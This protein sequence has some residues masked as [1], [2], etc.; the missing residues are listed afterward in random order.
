MNFA[1]Q[2]P[3]HMI[4][5]LRVLGGIALL[6][7]IVIAFFWPHAAMRS[8]LFG[9]LFFIDLTLG[10]LATLGMLYASGGAWGA[11]ARRI[12]EAGALTLPLLAVL[13]LPLLIGAPWVFPW[14]D[15]AEIAAEPVIAH[16]LPWIGLPWVAT[17]GVVF[18]A[19]LIGVTYW[20][21][22]LSIAWDA[23]SPP[24]LEPGARSDPEEPATSE[25]ST[26]PQSL[27]P[28]PL[29]QGTLEPLRIARRLD[30]LGRFVLCALFVIVSFWVVDFIMALEPKYTSTAFG[31]IMLCGQACGAMCVVILT[32]A[33]LQRR[34]PEPL[35]PPDRVHDLGKLLLTNLVMWAYT[36]FAQFL[37]QWQ[38]NTQ[39]DIPFYVHRTESWWRWTGTALIF[40]HLGLPF[41]LLMSQPL[42][43]D[44]RRLAWVAAL[45]LLMRFIDTLWLVA[46]SSTHEAAGWVYPTDLLTPI[47]VGALWMSVFLGRLCEAPLL[48]RAYEASGANETGL[49]RTEVPHAG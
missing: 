35:L 26:T 37:I 13:G 41:V 44:L 34:S 31:M 40:L 38:G 47:A 27:S 42:K 30:Y 28:S 39:N 17:R 21:R 18:F 4:T 23:S 25:T 3:S 32:F 24:P 8:Y 46:P 36:S 43:R 33:M 5:R 20:M 16:R 10:L 48:A 12:C 22:R 45:I 11:F 1:L 19:I 2:R 15:K 9:Y 6:A 14:A 29:R 7:W 49:V